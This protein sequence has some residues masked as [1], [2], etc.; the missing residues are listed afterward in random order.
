[1]HNAHCIKCLYNIYI[2]YIILYFKLTTNLVFFFL[3]KRIP[4]EHLKRTLLSC[5]RIDN[6]H[7]MCELV[8]FII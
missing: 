2:Y 4:F 8:I 1:M 7:N 5:G 3:F 6:M